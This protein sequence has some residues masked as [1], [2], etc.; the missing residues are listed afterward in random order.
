MCYF[1]CSWAN[2]LGPSYFSS[3]ANG[4]SECLL[5][6]PNLLHH[7]KS[8]WPKL[9]LI[10]GWAVSEGESRNW[11]YWLTI[12]HAKKSEDNDVF[13]CKTPAGK[14]NSVNVVVTGKVEN[15]LIS[16]FIQGVILKS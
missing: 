4:L 8:S 7:N 10:L 2:R 1:I 14:R 11:E 12:Y 6:N 13:T 5:S 15:D 3:S 16:G 9:L